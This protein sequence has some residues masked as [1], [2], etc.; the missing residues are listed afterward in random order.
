MDALK[1]EIQGFNRAVA[2]V[3]AAFLLPLMLLTTLEVISRNLLGHPI[4]GVI[5]LS[6]YLL[7]VFILLG[8]AYTQQVKGH[9]GVSLFT[10]RLKA[11]SKGILGMI[12]TFLSLFIFALIAWQAWVVGI[13]ERTVSDMLRIPQLP[14]RLL[15]A[16]GALLLCLELLI[17]LGIEVKK[18]MDKPS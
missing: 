4:P 10:S 11:R 6:G 1:R 7:A 13:G 8:L 5:E 9:I 16:V 3:G 17:D 15:V 14:F 2:G 18:F 12:T